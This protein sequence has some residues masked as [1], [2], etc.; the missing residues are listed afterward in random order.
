MER[1]RNFPQFM[2][3]KC[4]LT[5]LQNP[6]TPSLVL[7]LSQNITFHVLPFYFFNINF[8]I[9]LLSIRRSSTWCLAIQIILIQW[10][11]FQLPGTFEIVLDFRCLAPTP[12]FLD[13]FL[14]NQSFSKFIPYR[15]PKIIFYVL[16]K[17]AFASKKRK[18]HLVEHGNCTGTGNYQT[19]IS[20][21]KSRDISN[22]SR[23]FKMFMYLIHVFSRNRE[24]MLCETVAG[25]HSVR[26]QWAVN[27]RLFTSK[28]PV[29][30]HHGGKIIPH[31][32]L[33]TAQIL[34]KKSYLLLNLSLTTLTLKQRSILVI[35]KHL[36]LLSVDQ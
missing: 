35:N 13:F 19:K 34:Y 18:G 11:L 7:T 27:C 30:L 5:Y 29:R 9:V 20:H 17:R 6:T 22:F 21:D 23:Y 14:V 15:N 12:T 28:L 10:K 36:F 8:N 32:L 4:T 2:H 25:K 16:W 24:K 26:W 31:S 3:L 1:I 33:F